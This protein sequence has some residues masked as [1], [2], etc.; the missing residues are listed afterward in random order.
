MNE[1]N[2]TATNGMKQ[3]E[4]PDNKLQ[5]FE[6]RLK[7]CEKYYERYNDPYG[8]NGGNTAESLL[9]DEIEHL[10]RKID[11][12]DGNILLPSYSSEIVR[13]M[14]LIAKHRR[15][16]IEYYERV[17]KE[18]RL[19]ALESLAK[20]WEKRDNKVQKRNEGSF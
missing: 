19:P 3:E 2:E 20:S 9:R 16:K 15:E 5:L 12:R 4:T 1:I 14:K 8:V 17:L 11:E 7:R 10:E 18:D 6:D 13:I